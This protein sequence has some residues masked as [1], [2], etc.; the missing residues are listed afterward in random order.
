MFRAFPAR[1]FACSPGFLPRNASN[2][3]AAPSSRAWQACSP[4]RASASSRAAAWPCRSA[5]VARACAASRLHGSTG[6]AGGAARV[7]SSLSTARADRAMLEAGGLV[8]YLKRE[9][10]TAGA[11][12]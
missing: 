1:G 8:N 7:A 5:S 11:A 6:S 12:P 4:A 10:Q 9:I 3:L 2:S